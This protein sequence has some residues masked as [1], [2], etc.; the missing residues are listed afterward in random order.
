M[1]GVQTCALPIFVY[2]RTD[3][4]GT[5][6]LDFLADK[7]TK[8]AKFRCF[9]EDNFNATERLE[10]LSIAR[11]IE[12]FYNKTDGQIKNSNFLTRFFVYLR[13][14]VFQYNNPA[15][16]YS[17]DRG[18]LMAKCFSAYSYVDYNIRFN[19]R[20]FIDANEQIYEIGRFDKPKKRIILSQ[21]GLN[22]DR[23]KSKAKVPADY[24]VLYG[25]LPELEEIMTG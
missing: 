11:K 16:N 20:S 8:L 5:C 10:G 18:N 14:K 21:D 15:F 23:Y 24:C 13:L 4:K 6:S 25:L 3:Y 9:D 17:E 19:A 12:G 22:M 2:A 7:I 1:T